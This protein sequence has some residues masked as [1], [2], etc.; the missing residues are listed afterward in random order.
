LKVA[1]ATINDYKRDLKV[2]TN[3]PFVTTNNGLGRARK[4]IKGWK[5]KVVWTDGSSSWVPLRDLKES[6]LVE[7]AQFAVARNIVDKPAF[8]WWV[9]YTLRKKQVIISKL[10]ACL[11][12]MTHKYRV[13]MSTSVEHAFELDRSNGNTLWRNV[14][15]KE[16]VN[17]GIA[18][19]V[20]DH[21]CTTPIG[22]KNITGHL[23][24]DLKTDFTR[25]AR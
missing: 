8:A 18:F 2:V 17:V 14:L 9:P 3:E 7:V 1:L 20:L 24:W 21:G 23:V 11:R 16:M 5:L 10:K 15:S 4:T 12:K 19:E 22:R 25:K 13:K 6:H